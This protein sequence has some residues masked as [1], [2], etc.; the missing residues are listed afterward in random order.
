MID[1]PAREPGGQTRAPPPYMKKLIAMLAALAAVPAASAAGYFGASIGY[2]TDLEEPLYALQLGGTIAQSATQ[3]HNL[4]LE[5]GYASASESADVDGIG[6][7]GDADLT[8]LL[9]N[10]R[11]L[12]PISKG[13]DFYAGAGAGLTQLKMKISALG[14]SESDDDNVF[15][16]QVFAGIAAKISQT[17]SVTLGARYISLDNADLFDVEVDPGDDI[18]IELGVRFGF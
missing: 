3:S 8:M 13:V 14:D 6:V 11:L 5:F 9:G 1:L 4:E 17:A 18:A 12:V 2:L 16:W 7:D 15:T 10:Y